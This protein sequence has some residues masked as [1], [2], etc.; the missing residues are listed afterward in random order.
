[1]G[2][3]D[4]GEIMASKKRTPKPPPE[5]RPP[6]YLLTTEYRIWVV[7]SMGTLR[8]PYE[9]CRHHNCIFRL[10]GSYESLEAAQTAILEDD[11]GSNTYAVV[12][13]VTKKLNPR[14]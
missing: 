7:S 13:M 6:K 11:H 4:P 9:D 5:P 8:T 2:D 3:K 12:P 1:M 14:Y 10:D